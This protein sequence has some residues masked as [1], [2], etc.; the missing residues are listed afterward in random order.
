MMRRAVLLTALVA[1]VLST[2]AGPGRRVYHQAWQADT[3]ELRL[4]H[5]FGTA[6]LLSGTLLTP[7]FRKDLAVE[8]ARLLDSPAADVAAFAQQMTTDGAA[9]HEVV[10][11]AESPMQDEPLQFGTTDEDWQ[12][13]LT[14]DGT[15]EKLVAVQQ[16]DHPSALHAALYPQLDRW[17]TLW[18]ARFERSVADPDTVVFEVASGYGHGQLVWRGLRH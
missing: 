14:A 15:P 5:G 2:A 10:F 16:V 8:R 17:S 9:W 3:R 13:R 12:V 7:D 4:Y 6:L 11:A 18:I 1:L